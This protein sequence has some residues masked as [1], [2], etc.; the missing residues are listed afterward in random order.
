MPAPAGSVRPVAACWPR[1]GMDGSSKWRGIPFIRSAEGKLCARGQ[2]SL[3]GLYNP[4]RFPGPLMRKEKGKMDP[5][6]LATGGRSPGPNPDRPDSARAGANGIVFRQ[7]ID[8]RQLKRSGRPLAFGNGFPRP[9]LL[10]ESFAYEPLRQANRFVFQYDGFPHYRIDQA[11]FLISF[12]AGFLETWISNLEFARQFAV[13]HSLQPKG[14]NPFIFVGPRLSLTANNADQWIV[15]P[16]GDEYLIGLG[17]LRVLLDEGLTDHFPSDQRPGWPKTLQNFS[18]ERISQKTGV[19]VPVIR[20]LARRFSRAERPL[21]LAEG[22]GLSGPRALEAAVAANLLCLIKPGYPAGHRLQQSLGL[23]SDSP[24]GR[25]ERTFRKDEEKRGRSIAPGPGQSGF[26][27]S[28]F[29][30]VSKGPGSGPSGGQLLQL[31]W[32]RPAPWPTWSCPIIPF[33]NPG[34]TIRPG[35]GCRD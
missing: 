1:T 28:L 12:G 15:V 7:R 21:V 32:M 17:L 23:W 18:L 11:D 13:F 20:D 22:L 4:D 2:A 26:H 14:K 24:F 6:D 9:L 34:E 30:G 19:Q 5:S 33:W 16:P 8:K 31:S 10:Y 27:P 35:K 29:L 3:Q 25:D